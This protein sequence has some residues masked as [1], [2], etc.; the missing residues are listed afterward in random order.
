MISSSK[1]PSEFRVKAS[2]PNNILSSYE[3][4]TGDIKSTFHYEND[5]N[6]LNQDVYS[7]IK[8]ALATKGTWGVINEVK[9]NV[10]NSGCN[11]I[12]EALS[13]DKRP[14]VFVELKDCPS[15][16]TLPGIIVE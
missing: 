9:E 7:N 12:Q 1:V 10:G 16:E 15:T 6:Y 8:N 2:T 11:K 14:S 5:L 4:V 13:T 3:C